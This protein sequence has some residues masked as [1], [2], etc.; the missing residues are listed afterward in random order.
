MLV[1]RKELILSGIF[2]SLV[3]VEFGRT[4]GKRVSAGTDFI[5]CKVP[6]KTTRFECLERR[7]VLNEDDL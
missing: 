1:D 3:T 7:L 5:L 2:W 6:D 4:Y